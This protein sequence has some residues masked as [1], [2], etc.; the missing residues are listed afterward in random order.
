[1]SSSALKIVAI[2]SMTC[3]HIYS[4]L[5][6]AYWGL[7][8]IGRLAF[9]IF[10]WSIANG[11]DNTKN[12]KKYLIRLFLLAVISQIPYVFVHRLRDQTFWEL[13]VVFTLFSGLLA[14]S[15]IK[16]KQNAVIKAA[17]AIVIAALAQ[18]CRM[19]YGAVGVFS[20]ISFSMFDNRSGRLVVAQAILIVFMIW[21]T[22]YEVWKSDQLYP[23]HLLVFGNALALLALPLIRLYNRRQGINLKYFFYGFYPLHF[24][25]LYY[26]FIAFF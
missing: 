13:N 18:I 21:S 23:H 10:A 24:I 26:A 5:F 7:Y 1:M 2:V 3:S 6:P 17:A 20:I 9:P 22:V 8:L 25:A 16:S 12:I 15:I 4:H 11:A 14:V 19:D